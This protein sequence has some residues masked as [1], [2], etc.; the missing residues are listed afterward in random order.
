MTPNNN[1]VQFNRKMVGKTVLVVS[2]GDSWAGVVSDV[3][4]EKTFIVTNTKGQNK[5]VDIFDIR[6]F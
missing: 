5:N 6:S 1:K 2:Q 4:D 3:L